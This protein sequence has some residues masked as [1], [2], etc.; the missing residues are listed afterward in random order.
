MSRAKLRVLPS[1]AMVVLLF[2]FYYWL[3]L[4]VSCRKRPVLQRSGRLL[5]N[6]DDRIGESYPLG[7]VR[8]RRSVGTRGGCGEGWGPGACPGEWRVRQGF[9]LTRWILSPGRGQAQ[10]PILFKYVQWHAQFY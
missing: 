9:M 6:V 5:M 1:G 7:R 2:H 10:G 3:L 8:P 4:L